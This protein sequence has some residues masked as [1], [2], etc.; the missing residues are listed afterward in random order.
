MINNIFNHLQINDS[1]HNF[2]ISRCKVPEC[3]SGLNNR[4]IQY[5]QSWLQNA[6]PMKNDEIDNCQR[7]E[8]LQP[9][10]H[11]DQCTTDLFNTSK[12]IPC[13]EF[14]YASDEVNVQTEVSFIQV[15]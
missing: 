15:N 11:H 6:I 14:I 2:G 10:V 8:P 9:N 13:T 3:E 12:Q 4:D 5:D 1:V 7:Y